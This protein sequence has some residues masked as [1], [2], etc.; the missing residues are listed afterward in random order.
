MFLLHCINRDCGS[1]Q[2]GAEAENEDNVAEQKRQLG[3]K[4]LYGQI[5]QV[6]ISVKYFIYTIYG[7]NNSLISMQPC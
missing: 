2:I 5:I 3:K 7:H 4:V 6:V 1:I